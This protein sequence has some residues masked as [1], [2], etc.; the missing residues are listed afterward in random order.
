MYTIVVPRMRLE[1]KRT[2]C[3]WEAGGGGGGDEDEINDP[4]E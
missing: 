3:V 4:I 2:A 1:W